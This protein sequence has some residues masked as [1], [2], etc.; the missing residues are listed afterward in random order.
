MSSLF[1]NPIS[2]LLILAVLLGCSPGGEEATVESAPSIEAVTDVENAGEESVETTSLTPTEETALEDD[3]DDRDQ[4]V[5]EVPAGF[6]E[7]PSPNK[8]MVADLAVLGVFEEMGQDFNL[9]EPITRGEYLALL[10]HSNNAIRRSDK[11]I[12]LAP[13]HDPGFTD[14]EDSHPAYKYVQAFSNSGHSVGYQDGTFKPDQALTREEMVALKVPV[15]TDYTQN[16]SEVKH[17]SDADTISPEFTSYISLD[18]VLNGTNGTN[19]SRAFGSI[20]ALKPQEPVLGYE[21]AAAVWE[22]KG[23]GYNAAVDVSAAE[24]LEAREKE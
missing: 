1:K 22:Y 9:L 23:Y 2:S 20:K 24:A 13:V 18:Y 21:A 8:E 14:I 4:S 6:E 3:V 16:S 10:Y 11:H 17:F 19:I 5:A 15:D 7:T 12:R